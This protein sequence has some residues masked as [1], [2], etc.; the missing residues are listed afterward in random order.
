METPTPKSQT[1]RMPLSS[2]LY[3]QMNAATQPMAVGNHNQQ[4]ID[5]SFVKEEIAQFAGHNVFKK[6]IIQLTIEEYHC[7]KASLKSV[8][9][10]LSF[11]EEYN[12]H[13]HVKPS[14][15]GVDERTKHSAA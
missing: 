14:N 9:S 5:I 11:T 7:L 8:D 6:A 2:N 10:L 1:L 15:T 4:H 12:H 3:L 13:H